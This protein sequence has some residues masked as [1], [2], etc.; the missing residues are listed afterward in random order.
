[1]GRFM[2]CYWEDAKRY[3]DPEDWLDFGSEADFSTYL[4]DTEEGVVVFC[5]AMEPEDATLDRGLQPLV[6]YMEGL[7]RG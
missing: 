1:M 4:I 3:D 5:D 6:R 2:L 7:A